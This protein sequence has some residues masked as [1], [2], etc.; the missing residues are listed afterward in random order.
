MRFGA[1]PNALL[2]VRNPSASRPRCAAMA[3]LDRNPFY[4]AGDHRHVA[5]TSRGV[6]GS[7]GAYGS[8]RGRSC[9]PRT[10]RHAVIWRGSNAPESRRSDFARPPPPAAAPLEL[11]V[12]CASLRPKV[13]VRMDSMLRPRWA[14]MC[15]P[16]PTPARHTLRTHSGCRS[17]APAAPSGCPGRRVACPVMK[18]AS[19]PT[20]QL[21][22]RGRSHRA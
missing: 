15:S 19:G 4:R 22:I 18:L 1:S 5:T 11:G 13:T 20:S 21:P 3:D 14:C 2:P 17:R 6:R 8:T 7:L 9:L 16:R 12:A 10:L